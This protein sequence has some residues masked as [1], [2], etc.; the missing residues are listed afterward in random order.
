M[1]KNFCVVELLE[2]LEWFEG[3]GELPG[4]SLGVSDTVWVRFQMARRHY[5]VAEL[6]LLNHMLLELTKLKRQGNVYAAEI[7]D[8]RDHV[9]RMVD[10]KPF[11]M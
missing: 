2:N 3:D 9:Q 6:K 8:Y 11:E 4:V 10:N 7:L 1:R 5:L